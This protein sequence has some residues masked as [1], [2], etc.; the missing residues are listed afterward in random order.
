MYVYQALNSHIIQKR[1]ALGFNAQT[2]DQSM[3]TKPSTIS[4]L[5]EHTLPLVEWGLSYSE[6]S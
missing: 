2:S 4:A 3:L 1:F 6:T 5:C